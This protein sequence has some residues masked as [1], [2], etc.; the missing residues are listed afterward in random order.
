MNEIEDGAVSEAM[1]VRHG[2]PCPYCGTP[3]HIPLHKRSIRAARN[4]RKVLR[5]SPFHR[6]EL[7]EQMGFDPDMNLDDPVMMAGEC[8]RCGNEVTF[9]V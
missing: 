3:V 5:R 2:Q 8:R 7:D 9:V 6:R 4:V 1:E